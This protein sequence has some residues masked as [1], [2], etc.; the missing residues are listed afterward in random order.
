MWVRFTQSGR[1][2]ANKFGLGPEFVN[3]P[4]P[5]I[6]HSSTQPAYHL[7]QDVSGR[8]LVRDPSFDPLR[9]QL[10][11]R[12]LTFLEVPV[13]TSILHRGKAAH[14]ANHLE[15]TPFHENRFARTFLGSR[16]HRSHHDAR[17]ASGKRLYNVAG[18]L[19]PAVGDNRHVS[20]PVNRIEHRRELRYAYSR[21]DAR[22]ADRARPNADLDRIDT[23]LGQSPCTLASRNIARDE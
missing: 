6:P 12:H 5:S 14:A 16:E 7:E 13:C 3:S 19:D 21:H 18:V 2:D 17:C 22:G 20:G 23:T 4:A 10:L 15:A 9:H 8:P 1:S 11:G